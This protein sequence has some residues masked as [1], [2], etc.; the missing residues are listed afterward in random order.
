MKHNSLAIITITTNNII[1]TLLYISC[2]HSCSI[3]QYNPNYN[4]SILQY[5]ANTSKGN[6]LSSYHYYSNSSL[7]NYQRLNI[8][9]HISSPSSNSSSN[10]IQT[11]YIVTSLHRR[12]KSYNKNSKLSSTSS[13]TIS[14]SIVIYM[15][16]LP[17]Y[18]A[19]SDTKNPS[20][21]SVSA[22]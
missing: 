20:H 12:K 5:S 10:Q 14:L 1:S 7:T 17:I 8:T 22:S 13:L 6:Y 2:L 9:N 4:R 15:I 16:A 18:C 3:C 21:K 11:L 19:K